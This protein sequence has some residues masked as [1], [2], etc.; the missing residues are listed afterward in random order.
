M[1]KKTIIFLV[2]LGVA[3]IAAIALYGGT[4]IAILRAQ[5]W[6]VNPQLAAETSHSIIDYDLPDGYEEQQVLM[7]Q[8][9][10]RAVIISHR[11][12]PGDLIA[13]LPIPSGIIKNESWRTKYEEHNSR[14]V[15]K[16]RY[17]TQTIDNQSVIIR[18]Q[19]VNL[20]TLE[21]T[22]QNGVTIRQQVCLFESK[23]GELMLI[24][25][26]SR[27]TWDQELVDMF[28]QSVR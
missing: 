25:V 8:D 24:F 19:T 15:G 4:M 13:L 7:I 23:T 1:G 5:A 14:D 11:D 18:G 20:R 12:R 26:A 2:L 28:I 3:I 22:D 17:D 27:S 6:E 16:Y 21:G 10:P 9:A